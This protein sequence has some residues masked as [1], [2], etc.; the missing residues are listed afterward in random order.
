MA[1][2]ILDPRVAFDNV[3]MAA[4][5]AHG[6]PAGTIQRMAEKLGLPHQRLSQAVNIPLRTLARRLKQRTPLPPDE[7][8][9]VARL[10]RIVARATEVLGGLERAR[11]WMME[12]P[13]GLGGKT[14]L[15][16]AETEPGARAVEDLLGRL[17][18]G[19]IA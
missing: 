2:D 13:R 18:H 9:R 7:S 6:L 4:A 19:V 1:L 16:F 10:G 15:D 8:E 17:E 3:R 14:P 11:R 12:R 5:V